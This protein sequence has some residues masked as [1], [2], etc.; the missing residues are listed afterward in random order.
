[1]AKKKIKSFIR[2]RSKYRHFHVLAKGTHIQ[3]LRDEFLIPNRHLDHLMVDVSKISIHSIGCMKNPRSHTPET[4]HTL[5]D[6]ISFW[7][8]RFF[9]WKNWNK[10]NFEM[11]KLNF[12]NC[13]LPLYVWHSP[14]VKRDLCI[15]FRRMTW[16][17]IHILDRLAGQ[18]FRELAHTTAGM[19]SADVK[20]Q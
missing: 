12:W 11:E 7:I 18:Q 9:L 16:V 4:K 10:W 13:N 3:P 15:V 20:I 2:D 6:A 1:M 17:D 5:N 8:L 14:A 19:F